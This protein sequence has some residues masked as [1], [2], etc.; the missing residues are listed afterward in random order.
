MKQQ[1]FGVNT[2]PKVSMKTKWKQEALQMGYRS[3]ILMKDYTL[4]SS[5]DTPVRLPQLYSP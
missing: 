4:L 3:L 2:I 5:S 1:E